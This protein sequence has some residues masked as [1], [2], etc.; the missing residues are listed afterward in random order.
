MFFCSRCRKHD[1]QHVENTRQQ[2]GTATCNLTCQGP[3]LERSQMTDCRL[4][5]PSNKQ[6]WVV[7]HHALDTAKAKFKWTR[8]QNP[9]ITKSFF[10]SGEQG[11]MVDR[12]PA[13][14]H[15]VFLEELELKLSSSPVGA[16]RAG[17]KITS[18]S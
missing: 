15:S 6:G 4:T 8:P 2:T 16:R 17:N 10:F 13:R 5:P 11:L 18:W 14:R 7:E 12:G 1:K 9:C 3:Q